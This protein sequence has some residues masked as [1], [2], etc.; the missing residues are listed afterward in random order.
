MKILQGQ[1][2]GASRRVAP[3]SPGETRGGMI[4]RPDEKNKNIIIK[5]NF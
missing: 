3:S 5:L 1:V 2:S 4:Q